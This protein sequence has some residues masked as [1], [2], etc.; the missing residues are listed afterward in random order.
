MKFE[1]EIIFST[2]FSTGEGQKTYRA[3]T[4]GGWIVRHY[5]WDI[6]FRQIENSMVFV[7]DPEHNWEIDKE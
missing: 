3:K 1:W 2:Q 5:Q 4:T 6:Q 7:P